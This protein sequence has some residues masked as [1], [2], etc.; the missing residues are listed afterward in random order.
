MNSR[1]NIGAT[2]RGRG[3]F[4]NPPDLGEDPDQGRP[5]G[6]SRAA[7]GAA[8][9]QPRYVHLSLQGSK[10]FTRVETSRHRDKDSNQQRVHG[11]IA[12]TPHHE[13]NAPRFS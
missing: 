11:G 1:C 10:S 5:D 9:A 3:A 13:G 12:R 7:E 8:S 2:R 6:Q 4:A